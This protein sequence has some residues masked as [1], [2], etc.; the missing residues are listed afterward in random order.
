MLLLLP[1]LQWPRSMLHDDLW[2]GVPMQPWAEQQ[3]EQG[4]AQV[5]TGSTRCT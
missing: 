4:G 5:S 3:Q 1:C 2:G